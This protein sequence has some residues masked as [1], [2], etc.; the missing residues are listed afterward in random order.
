MSR[1]GSGFLIVGTAIV[2]A[3]LSWWWITYGEVVKYGYLSWREASDCLVWNSDIC[4]LATAL[5]LGSHPR[6]LLSY[7]SSTLWLGL[8]AI[9]ASLLLAGRTKAAGQRANRT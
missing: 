2:V 5:C 6:A 8:I 1:A 7:W 9:S 3:A 4:S